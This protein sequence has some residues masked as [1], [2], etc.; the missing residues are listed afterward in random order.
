VTPEDGKNLN[1]CFPGSY[2]GTFSDALA[3]AVF[4]TLIEPAGA[5]IDLHGGDQVEALEPFS[6]YDASDVE[7]E[8]RALA[9]A[10][11]LP[12]V[13]R[14]V[15]SGAPI[16]GTTSSAAASAGVPAVI[17]EAGGCGLLEEHAVRLHLDGLANALKQL[18]ILP[19][20]PEP[21]PP[22]MRSVERFVWIRSSSEGWWEPAVRAG[23]EVAGASHL[24]VVR[25]PY[26]DVVE[27]IVAPD[28]GVALFLTTSPA[29]EPDGLLL[30]LG[31]G[32][33]PVV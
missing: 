18:G 22:G 30:G 26:G 7:D 12:Y 17:A 8:A 3:R 13:L 23:E 6:L 4:E 20:D 25:D 19:G 16:S 9:V 1:R 14:S 21:S 5:L 27:E 33:A 2:D 10:F 11:G 32:V 28:D 24:G 29:V 15:P 31:V